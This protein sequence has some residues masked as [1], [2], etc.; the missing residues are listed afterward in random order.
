MFFVTKGGV[1]KQVTLATRPMLNVM[2]MTGGIPVGFWNDPAILGFLWGMMDCLV[3]EFSNQRYDGTVRNE[4]VVGVV[5]DL[6]GPGSGLR[7][8]E[9]VVR[10]IESRQ[11]DFEQGL[12]AGFLSV[13]IAK[14]GAAAVL[15][16]PVVEAAIDYARTAPDLG[17]IN[18][19]AS[20]QAKISSAL[21]WLYFYQKASHLRT[22]A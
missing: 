22:L 2:D 11:P 13:A 17:P 9:T 4:I 12:K 7:T 3:L 15:D 5:D 21:Q 19:P 16:E 14:R 1:R 6:Q 18:R 8:A 10:L 20:E